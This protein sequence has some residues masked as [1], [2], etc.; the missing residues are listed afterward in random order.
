MERPAETS[1]PE[2]SPVDVLEAALEGPNSIRRLSV[3]RL[4]DRR[5]SMA[6]AIPRGDPRT[7]VSEEVMSTNKFGL[8]P[9]G[10]V[11]LQRLDICCD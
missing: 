8:H 2:V 11:N 5:G 4:S 10:P 9:A 1:E 6:A 3:K 7:A